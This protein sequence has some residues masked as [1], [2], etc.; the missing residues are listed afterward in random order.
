M[1]INK[2]IRPFLRMLLPIKDY[3]DFLNN[4]L[5]QKFSNKTFKKEIIGLN[6][7]EAAE[8]RLTEIKLKI[9]VWEPGG[10]PFFFNV[11]GLIAWALKLRGCSVKLL[12]C[13][14]SKIAC[15][16]RIFYLKDD[17]K[18]WHK[19]CNRCSILCSEYIKTLNLDYGFIDDYIGDG[20]LEQLYKL[21]QEIKFEDIYDF[22]FKGY[23]I[24]KNVYS[25]FRRYLRGKPMLKEQENILR[26][27]LY[28]GMANIEMA[29]NFVAKEKPDRVIMS[30]SVY[31]D[32][33]S[34]LQVFLKNKI[35][36]SVG[37]CSPG[38][39]GNRNDCQVFSFP[40]D[41]KRTSPQMILD[42]TWDNIK[43]KKLSLVEEKKLEE[44]FSQRYPKNKSNGPNIFDFGNNNPVCC[45]FAHAIWDAVDDMYQMVYK[46][47]DE[48]MIDTIKEISKIKNINWL[49]KVHPVEFIE[50]SGS[51]KSY[52]VC[53]VIENNFGELPSHIKILKNIAVN[54]LELY[55][56]ISMAITVVGTPGLEVAMFGKPVIVA[57]QAH[58]AKKGF[59]YDA[60]TR[61]EYVNYL[62]NIKQL[63]PL[64]KFQIEKAKQY[65]YL[66][67]A[68][69]Q[70]P[71]DYLEN[72]DLDRVDTNKIK[73][74]IFGK[75]KYMDFICDCIINKKDFVLP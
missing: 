1:E 42:K 67:F 19:S 47:F 21:S 45:I 29:E 4:F 5:Y 34:P 57:G 44:I 73:N 15:T 71:F 37:F 60:S 59:T 22:C 6:K 30:H 33:G 68:R 54:N 10:Y 56:K 27:Y 53:D 52:G 62:R 40:E 75:D 41:L 26:F 11:F 70:I 35:T 72:G 7:K 48:W 46:D 39:V 28:A 14:G 23:Y 63:K 3:F 16:K 65:A 55:K 8:G 32:Y 9:F 18:N 31:T 12:L 51:Q 43:N 74:I 38:V 69:K 49:I 61:E 20:Q 50:A 66:H 13:K 2:N 58:Y 64:S 24:G 25:S 17:P 36:V